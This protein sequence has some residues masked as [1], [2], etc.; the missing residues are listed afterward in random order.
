MHAIKL[1]QLNH[2]PA[3]TNQV[4]A[5]PQVLTITLACRA[6]EEFADYCLALGYGKIKCMQNDLLQYRREIEDVIKNSLKDQMREM[7]VN[8]RL[9]DS[10]CY[11]CWVNLRLTL[12]QAAEDHQPDPQKVC[13]VYVCEILDGILRT[14]P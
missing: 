13:T 3:K 4:S 5:T 10:L 2:L 8:A 9:K 11:S 12:E 6:F 7:E 14:L 1:R